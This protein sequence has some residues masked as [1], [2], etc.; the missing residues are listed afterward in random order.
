MYKSKEEKNVFL[1]NTQILRIGTGLL[2]VLLISAC[3]TIPHAR[4]FTCRSSGKARSKIKFDGYP[5]RKIHGGSKQI[6]TIRTFYF[7]D[8]VVEPT[9]FE[10]PYTSTS[11]DLKSQIIWRLVES[12]CGPDEI[13]CITPK[14][15]PDN[16]KGGKGDDRRKYRIPKMNIKD[17]LSEKPLV[18]THVLNVGRNTSV[19]GG[20]NRDSC[21]IFNVYGDNTETPWCQ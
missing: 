18:L 1:F 10:T 12:L 14:F 19:I 6:G 7:H 2:L 20:V 17:N 3:S 4:V 13:T 5:E 15:K 16:F 11:L 8:A 21:F 9:L